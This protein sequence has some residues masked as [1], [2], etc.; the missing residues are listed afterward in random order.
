MS[1]L[2]YQNCVLTVIAVCLVVLTLDKISFVPSAKAETKS[3]YSLVPVNP[4]GSINVRVKESV[5]VNID[6]VDP[7][8]FRY[9]TVPVKIEQ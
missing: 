1:K 3:N 5:N 2:N 6:E 4:D 7:Y 9:C 8:A